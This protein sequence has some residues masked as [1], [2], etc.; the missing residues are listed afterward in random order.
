MLS[1]AVCWDVLE[2]QLAHSR[3]T[4]DTARNYIFDFALE[5]A[6]M[7]N[8]PPP[9][10][11][12]PKE[13]SLLMASSG[14]VDGQERRDHYYSWVDTKRGREKSQLH[15][16]T[17]STLRAVLDLST[18]LSNY[19]VP[20]DTGLAHYVVAKDD[21]YV[22]RQHIANMKEVWPGVCAHRDN[23]SRGQN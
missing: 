12:H 6:A 15:W 14:G 1:G 19:P 22:P 16:E 9:P 7:N 5:Q 17:M 21:L 10:P 3:S 13:G 18:H 20:L 11:P 2:D 23:L 4:S 8:S